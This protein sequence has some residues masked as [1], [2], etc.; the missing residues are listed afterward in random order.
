M[1]FYIASQWKFVGKIYGIKA[2]IKVMKD[3]KDYTYRQL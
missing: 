3:K 1:T 2:D